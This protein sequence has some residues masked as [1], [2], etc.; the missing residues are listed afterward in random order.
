LNYE[1]AQA[2]MKRLKH[3]AYRV[4][5]MHELRTPDKIKAVRYRHWLR[6]FVQNGVDIFGDAFRM[7]GMKG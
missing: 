7:Y 4:H 1:V 6:Q 5:T 2:A 3:V